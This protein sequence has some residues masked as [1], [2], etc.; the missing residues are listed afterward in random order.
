MK[1]KDKQERALLRLQNLFLY[2]DNAMT[3]KDFIVRKKEI[4][5]RIS[6]ISGKLG[7]ITHT[8]ES[9][10]SDE[11]F[12]RQASHLLIVNRLKDREYVYYRSLASSTSPEVLKEFVQSIVDSIVLT[13][14]HITRLVF[15]N[16]LTHDFI[17]K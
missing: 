11:D 8:A 13:D 7:M 6:E 3:E 12:I 4:A 16:G 10:L 14:G 2:S 9:V 5:D 17:W 15:R 1:E